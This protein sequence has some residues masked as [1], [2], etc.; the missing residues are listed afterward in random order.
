[1]KLK[2]LTTESRNRDTEKLD[3]MTALE[4]VTAMNREDAAVPR[5]IE[6]VLPE[7][8][9][10]VDL[11]AGRL[12]TGGRLIYVG[13]GTSGRIGALDAS[14]CPPTF[15]TNPE[16]VQFLI[17]GGESALTQSSEGSEDS[18]EMGRSDIAARDPGD[19]DVVVGLAASGCTPYTISA[20]QYA[21]SKGATTVAI[22]CNH[23]SA[24][25]RAADIQIEVEV[26]PEALTGSSR[27]KAG[28]A[29]KLICNMLTT[30]AMARMGY[31]YSNLM[32]NLHLTNKKLLERGIVILESLANV[33][34]DA[35]LQV[36]ETADMSV[37]VAL[38]ML[39]ANANKSESLERL[40]KAKGNVRKAIEG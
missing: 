28:T 5:A 33:S 20:L 1:M 9:K 26:G 32:V 4:L 36:L 7:I 17:A 38:V 39:K 25:G 22:A 24:L 30:G 23:D 14:E 15:S 16:M 10:A 6:R 12:A 3:T 8:A 19:C 29:Q 21:G 2:K 35:A 31:V 18:E 40:R 13:S 34:R 11:I 37:P 27:L